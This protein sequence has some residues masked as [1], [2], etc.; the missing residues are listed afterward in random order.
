MLRIASEAFPGQI[1][2]S[3]LGRALAVS[4]LAAAAAMVITILAGMDD[5]DEYTLR[6]T[7]RIA[8]RSG[9]V[10]HTDS[11]DLDS[12]CS[13]VA[14][15]DEITQTHKRLGCGHMDCGGG[16]RCNRGVHSR[17]TADCHRLADR[18]RS[19][20][21]RIDGDDLAAGV[22]HR[23]CRGEAAA[24]RAR[25]TRIGVAPVECDG[26]AIVQA[27]CGCRRQKKAKR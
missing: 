18:E 22:R 13:T 9:N 15:Q 2:I 26:R 8:R 7:R 5:D 16:R 14:N 3:N 25:R 23:R 17:R 19:V 27:E 12:R 6:V 24:R 20:S 10:Q 1:T 11:A 21:R 4:L